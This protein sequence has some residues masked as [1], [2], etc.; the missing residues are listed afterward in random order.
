MKE[1][2]I[3]NIYSNKKRDWKFEYI[4]YFSVFNSCTNKNL[5]LRRT[6]IHN[7]ED[8]CCSFKENIDT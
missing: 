1:G 6:T 2:I 8:C 3:I 7:I 5:L 4:K